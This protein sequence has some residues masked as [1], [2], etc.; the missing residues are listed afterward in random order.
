MV[1]FQDYDRIT[2]CLMFLNNNITLNFTVVLSRKGKDG[3]KVFF[4]SESQYASKYMGVDKNRAIRRNMS[5]YFTLDNRNDF[6][7]GFILRPQDVMMLNMLLEQQVLPWFFGDKR[8]FNI[9]D[10][11]LVITGQWQEKAYAQSEYKY[12]S[13]APIVNQF[14]DGSFKEGVRVTL[15]HKQ[16]YADMDI[17]KFMQ[18]VYIL[19]NTDMYGAACSLTTYVKQPPYGVNVY[20]ATGLGGGYVP[21]QNWEANDNTNNGTKGYG[22]G[23]NNFLDGAKTK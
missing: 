11:K 4:H 22:L 1:Q 3:G 19:K 12:I 5:F 14:E 17:D 8:I 7:N 20:S 18:L 6:G 23:K 21:D 13:F 16:E 15:N 2:D 9:V 10:N